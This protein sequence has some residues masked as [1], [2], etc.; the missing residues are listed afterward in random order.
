MDV[1]RSRLGII[2]QSC[3]Y[4]AV[5]QQ[6]SVSDPLT[7]SGHVLHFTASRLNRNSDET[8]S[9]KPGRTNIQ[10]RS[11]SAAVNLNNGNT[12]EDFTFVAADYPG[13]CVKLKNCVN[14]RGDI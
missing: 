10:R 9:L 11:V 5:T 4:E 1:S 2:S 8:N 3:E 6:F 13:N 14:G 7:A 12:R